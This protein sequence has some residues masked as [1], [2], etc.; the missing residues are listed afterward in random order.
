MARSVNVPEDI[1]NLISQ[2]DKE[3]EIK[4]KFIEDLR[5]SM[6]A[7]C[8]GGEILMYLDAHLSESC[9]ELKIESKKTIRLLNKLRSSVSRLKR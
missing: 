6:K 2:I 3:I 8:T 1:E 7:G 9:C 5:D 4:R